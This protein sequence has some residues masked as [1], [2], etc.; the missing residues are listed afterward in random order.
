ME[1][2]RKR[3]WI[4]APCPVYDVEGTEKWLAQMA[5]EGWLLSEEGF[6]CGIGVFDP[7]PPRRTVF[8]LSVDVQKKA[9]MDEAYG[10]DEELIVRIRHDSGYES[11]YGNL[12]ECIPQ[13]GDYMAGGDVIGT[14]VEGKALAFE[15]RM[16]EP[17]PVTVHCAVGAR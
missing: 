4:L 17:Q 7:A 5:R 14:L 3:R 15:L 13:V 6:F 8:R 2:E 1:R 9:P 10:P 16:S 12:S 11:I